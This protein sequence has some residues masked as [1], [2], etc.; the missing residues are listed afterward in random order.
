[1]SISAR[2][3]QPETSGGSKIAVTA[4]T[5]P[6]VAVATSARAFQNPTASENESGSDTQITVGTGGA[7]TLPKASSATRGPSARPP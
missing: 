4:P 2:S 6:G 5:L 1:L 3:S 7:T